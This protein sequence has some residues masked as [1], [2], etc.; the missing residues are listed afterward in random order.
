MMGGKGRF[1][2]TLFGDFDLR[3]FAIFVLSGEDRGLA[4]VVDTFVHARYQTGVSIFLAFSS[5]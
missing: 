4:Q 1:V 5:W 3:L 2:A